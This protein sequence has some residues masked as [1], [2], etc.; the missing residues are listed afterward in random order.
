MI[1]VAPPLM[2][3]LLA[4]GEGVG[5]IRA[6]GW[7]FT[8][9]LAVIVH[10][11]L[12]EYFGHARIKG[13]RAAVK[14]TL[15]ACHVLHALTQLA[16]IGQFSAFQTLAAGVL[17]LAGSIICGWLLL[18]PITGS[19]ADIAA[20]LGFLPS[21]WLKLR[22]V[23]QFAE[24]G[25]WAHRYE[26][27]S[28][29][30]PGLVV[31]LLALGLVLA[32]DIGAYVCGKL[33]GRAPLSPVSPRKTIEGAC[34]GTAAA[35]VVGASSAVV[36]GWPLPLLSGALLGLL[37]ALF[38]LVGD[39]TESMMK[40]DAGVKDSGDLIPGHGGILDRVDSYLFTPAVVFYFVAGLLPLI[41][42]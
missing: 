41:P 7:W 25:S 36:V 2:R 13:I 9:L 6:G 8:L 31:T 28:G 21:H 3:G 35:A 19:I 27:S 5:V 20:Y 17:P 24:L 15:V 33:F 12:V 18:Q 29:L 30:M 4:A 10:L 39:L 16:A 37:V 42:A 32:A 11:A 14:T 23:E 34:G 38:A 26:L 1:A 40:R 22:A